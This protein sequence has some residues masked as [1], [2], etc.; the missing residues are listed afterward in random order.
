MELACRCECSLLRKHLV[1]DRD[2]CSAGRFHDQSI[3]ELCMAPSAVA[4]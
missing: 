3:D 1:P 2:Q 4:T